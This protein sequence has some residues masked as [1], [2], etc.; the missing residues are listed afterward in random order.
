MKQRKLRILAIDDDPGD[1]NLLRRHLEAIGEWEVEFIAAE[2]PEEAAVASSRGSI[3]VVL[4]DYQLGD[5]TGLE[6]LQTLSGSGDA[7]SQP[8]IMITGQGDEEIAAE[9]IKSGASD[10]IPK[11]RLGP[12][13]LQVAIRRAL[14]VS[15]LRRQLDDQRR[16]LER[17]ARQDDLTGLL[18]RRAWTEGAQ[19]E[20]LRSR[21]YGSPLSLL[22]LDMDHFKQV[23]DIHGH[24]AGDAV[25]RKA[26]RLIRERTRRTDLPG[27]IGGDEFCVLMVECTSQQATVFAERLCQEVAQFVISGAGGKDFG[28]TCS[29]GVAERAEGMNEMRDLIER[30][31]RALYRA[32]TSGRDRV[33][34]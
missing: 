25:L 26:G 19:R 16:E 13:G 24:V 32:K 5:R 4:L 31:D 17:L 7:A 29:I 34:S 18:N 22:M 8:V 14:E 30:A 21:R 23:N 12:R 9:A 2:S 11:G 27:R 10:Y 3:D 15:G 6:V 28:V 33:S 20:V 1:L